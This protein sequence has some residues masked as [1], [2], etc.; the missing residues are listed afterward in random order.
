MNWLQQLIRAELTKRGDIEQDEAKHGAFESLA[1]DWGVAAP[2]LRKWWRDGSL[3]HSSALPA[4]FKAMGGDFNRALPYRNNADEFNRASESLRSENARMTDQLKISEARIVDLEGV[5]RRLRA[6]IDEAVPQADPKRP[7]SLYRP[8]HG[9][10]WT[11]H[12]DGPT[13][14][15]EPD[16]KE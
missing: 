6:T 14:P 16:P 2:T 12:E 5:L 4:L 8:Q 11:L 3:P 7:P 10:A 1:K 9:Q 13:K 15:P